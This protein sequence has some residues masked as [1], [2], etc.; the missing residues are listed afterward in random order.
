MNKHIHYHNKKIIL[1]DSL[2]EKTDNQHF[3]NTSSLNEKE[4]KTQ[5][6]QFISA[7]DGKDLFLHTQNPE[8]L[9]KLIISE[10][11]FIEAAGGLIQK[12]DEFLFIKRLD[13][14]DLPKGKID[15]GEGKKEAAIR[16]CEEEC[17]V[18]D[19]EIKKQL[20]NTYHIYE[21]KDGFAFKVTY[22]YHMTTDYSKA[23]KPQ[24]EEN[25]EEVRWFKRNDIQHTVLKNTYATIE[26]LVVEFFT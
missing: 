11:Y 24:T 10:F 19:L 1:G 26:G 7:T 22:W 21:Y 4:I 25:I 13:K 9:L 20:N 5:V 3:I 16:E 18:H 6:R 8:S 14:W 15:K 23:L 17:D 12:N 2:L